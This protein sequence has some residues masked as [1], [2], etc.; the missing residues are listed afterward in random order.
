[1]SYDI[2][3]KLS[4][5]GDEI[6]L[7]CTSCAE[8]QLKITDDLCCARSICLDA[9]HLEELCE[10]IVTVQN[11]LSDLKRAREKAEGMK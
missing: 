9:T 11:R 10:M 4:A 6:T 7:S 1:M 2:E 8:I 5:H 3:M